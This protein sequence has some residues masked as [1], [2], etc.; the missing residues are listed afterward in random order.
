[1]SN[2][3]LLRSLLG[4]SASLL[5]PLR[6]PRTRILISALAAIVFMLLGRWWVVSLHRSEQQAELRGLLLTV[7]ET[8]RGSLRTWASSVRARAIW[9]TESPEVREL[10]EHLLDSSRSCDGLLADRA[11]A[12]LQRVLQRS[13]GLLTESAVQLDSFLLV[14]PDGFVAAASDRALVG[15]A[16]GLDEGSA[17]KFALD[18]EV[19]LRP[20]PRGSEESERSALAASNGSELLV[21][22]PVRGR[23]GD[24]IAAFGFPLNANANLKNLLRQGAWA[25]PTPMRGTGNG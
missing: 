7:L 11:A 1:M 20:L 13:D 25:A 12:E 3:T 16:A 6:R 19:R 2:T 8:T 24:V 9:R 21:A 15:I 23:S 4:V 18:G 22:V 5:E 17:L 10:V 14:A